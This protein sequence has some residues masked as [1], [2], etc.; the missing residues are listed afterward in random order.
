MGLFT[1]GKTLSL[2]FGSDFV[3]GVVGK[4]NKKAVTVE[5]SFK[6]ELPVGLYVDGEILDMDQMTYLLRSG[7]S[8][9]GVSNMNTHG[10]VN[11]TSVVMREVTL[12]KVSKEEIEAIITY[13]LEDYIPIN[14]EDYVVNY[15]QLG[16]KV[17]EGVE[18]LLLLLVGIPRTMIQSH[19][20][21]MKNVNLKPE[22]LDY[23]GNAIAKLIATGGLINDTY[24]NNKTI[25]C[26]D[27]GAKYTDLT[28]IDDS[29]VR[30]ARVIE[31]GFDAIIEN[32]MMKIP[33][34]E[35]SDID[36]I[37]DGIEDISKKPSVEDENALFKETLRDNLYEI[38]DR[39][40][41]IFRYYKTREVSNEINL[42]LVHGGL[43]AIK[44]ID[45]MC[46]DFFD[47]D[48]TVLR[49]LNKIRFNDRL[50]L[51]ANAIGGLV[52]LSEV[53]K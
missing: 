6:I 26:I 23:H 16:S 49:S 51:Y 5:K 25:A 7:L 33:G 50:G 31:K 3:K 9:N 20:T 24:D 53:K 12:P 32:L 37:I 13:Q 44:G 28:I 52:R 17:E 30:V 15:L 18:K 48:S 43:S 40:E 45:K 4:Y 38:L 35:R 22:V 27:L 11:S 1:N 29:Q 41:M 42:I 10:V 34:L 19:L 2:D 46:I 21:L 8:E 14:P 39:V 36:R 47:M